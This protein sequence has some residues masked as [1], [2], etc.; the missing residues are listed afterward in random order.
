MPNETVAEL[1]AELWCLAIH[2]AYSDYSSET[3]HDRI[4]C[5]L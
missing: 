2:R 4:V 5:G 3:I 1:K